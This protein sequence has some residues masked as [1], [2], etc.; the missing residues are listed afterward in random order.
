MKRVLLIALALAWIFLV[1]LNYY[2][3]HKPFSAENALAILNA[4][5]DVMIAGALVALGAAVGHRVL[6]A[7]EFDSPFDAL[8]LQT[9]LGLGLLALATFA[10]GLVIVHRLVFWALFVLGVFFLRDD[11]RA[12]WRQA[13]ALQFPIASRFERVLALFVVFTLIIG[14]I[15]A[16]LPPTAWD[17]QTYHL[18]IPKVALEQGRI[19]APPDIVY[20][21]FPSLGQMLFLAGM[22]LKGDVVAQLVHFVF[23]LLTLGAVFTFALRE[24][25]SRVAW[26]A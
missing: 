17:A 6:R 7:L 5:S 18:V 3:V 14:G 22:M 26:L 4:L 13:R 25:N 20:F 16:L 23:L 24:F 15:V 1:T 21:S 8:I 2:I 10:L 11:L 12:V 9:G 19:A